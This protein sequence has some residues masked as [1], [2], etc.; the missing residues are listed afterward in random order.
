[1]SRISWQRRLEVEEEEVLGEVMRRSEWK[2]FTHWEEEEEADAD[3]TVE[4]IF[5]QALLARQNLFT[6]MMTKTMSLVA[7]P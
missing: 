1:M 7:S 5:G 6:L 3:F 4:S 2:V